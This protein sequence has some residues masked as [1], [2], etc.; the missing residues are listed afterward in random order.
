MGKAAQLAQINLQERQTYLLELRRYFEQKLTGIS[1][2]QI[3]S[4]SCGRLPNTSYFSIP[5][6]HGET[7][8]MQLDQAGFELAS[9]SACHSAVT[10][11]SHVL[12]AMGVDEALALNAVRVSFGS[13]NTY[14]QI[15]QLIALLHSLI[16]QVPAS[17]RRTA[18]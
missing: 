16:N 11:P 3:F 14:Q 6:Y 1:G 15:D 4:N 9:G 7:L 17:F 2:V 18:N 12:K 5:Y 10:Q 8:L 13:N